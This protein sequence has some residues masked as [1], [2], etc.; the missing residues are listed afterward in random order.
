MSTHCVHNVGT[1]CALWDVNNAHT[2][3]LV[4]GAFCWKKADRS[5]LRPFRTL[6][7]PSGWIHLSPYLLATHTGGLFAQN[8][9]RTE[10]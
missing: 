10:K 6:G 5:I 9:F 2:I 8:C 7:N 4:E 1:V 3:E